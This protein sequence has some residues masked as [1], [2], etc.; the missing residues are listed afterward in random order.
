M[1]VAT[2]T[3]IIAGTA[4]AGAGASVYGASKAANAQ[5]KAAAQASALERESNA[6][7]RAD[8]AP[9]REAGQSALTKYAD[10]LGLNGDAARDQFRADFR[11]DPGYQFAFDEGQRA[12]QGSAAARGG[13][14]SGGALRALQ[15]TGQGMADQQY[16]SYLD[17]F[18]YLANMG[19]N[20]AA[21]TGQFGAQSAGRQGA[22]A[23]DAGAA[24][25][26]G[27]LSAAQG[28]NGALSNGLQL[29]GY[30]NGNRGGGGGGYNP[31][32]DYLGRDAREIFG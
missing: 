7:I 13:L 24:R 21:Q 5:K 32:S 19:Q 15:R 3:A 6:Q 12:V 10:S 25:A 30:M 26:G 16:G 18:G 17:R 11:A 29:Y 22:Y 2:S 27:Y 23:L 20:S 8:F 1:P 31:Y 14:L 9:Y 28:F 4:L